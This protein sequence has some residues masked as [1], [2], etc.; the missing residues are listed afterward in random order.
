MQFEDITCIITKKSWGSTS[1]SSSSQL[2][3]LS[4]TKD[5]VLDLNASN[6]LHNMSTV[7]IQHYQYHYICKNKIAVVHQV[8]LMGLVWW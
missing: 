6:F 2:K 8:Y 7:G 3:F 4:V 1:S 5:C